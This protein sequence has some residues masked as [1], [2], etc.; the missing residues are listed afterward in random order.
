[1][2]PPWR[3]AKN[4]IRGKAMAS[5]KSRPRWILWVWNC[6]WLILVAKVLKLCT[7]HVL[8][9]LRRSEWMNKCLSFFLVPSQSSNTPLYPRSAS[10]Q[11]VCLD[12][13]PFRCFHFRF[14]FESIKEFGSASSELALWEL[15]VLMDFQIFRGRLHGSKLIELNNFLYHWK[16]SRT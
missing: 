13:L 14:S 16:V 1:M 2:W 11:G 5:P 12:S 4:T 6:P 8:F 3:A 15:R 9:G 10:N 7:N